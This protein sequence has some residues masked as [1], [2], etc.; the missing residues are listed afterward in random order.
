[1]V[2]SLSRTL[3]NHVEKYGHEHLKCRR[4]G[5]PRPMRILKNPTRKTNGNLQFFEKCHEF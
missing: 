4:G 3:R 5:G 1:M 2:S